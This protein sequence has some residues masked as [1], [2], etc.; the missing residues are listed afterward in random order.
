MYNIVVSSQFKKDL[1]RLKKRSISNFKAMQDF[2][3][4][5][6]ETGIEGVNSK[7]KPHHLKGNYKGCFECH[8][9]SDV[10]LIWIEENH[11][12]TIY[13]VRTGTHSDLF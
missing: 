3:N 10:L 13:L 1:K 4:A 8:V 6:V 11:P 9:K 5:L 12:N 2:V 7:Y